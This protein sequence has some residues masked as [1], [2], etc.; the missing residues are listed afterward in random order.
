MKRKIARKNIAGYYAHISALDDYVGRVTKAI[1]ELGIEENTLLV[2]TSDHGDML[3]SQ[4]RTKKQQPWEESINVPMLLRFP[5]KNHQK[6]KRIALPINTP[7]LMP[8]FLGLC[9]LPIPSS[10][11]GKDY[12]NRITQKNDA[13]DGEEE[14]GVLITCPWMFSQFK[15]QKG[16]RE[17]RGIRTARYTYVRGLNGPWLL[18]DNLADPFQ[19][20]NIIRSRTHSKEIKNLDQ[21]LNKKLLET[22]DKFEP[23]INHINRLGY[24]TKKDGS[25]AYKN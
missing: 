7:D 21:L 18:Y 10:V 9:E 23:G 19:K 25:I 12:S 22:N 14:S 1:Q 24:K 20:H 3:Y 2:F 6:N 4:G 15:S 16:A 17:F 5:A 13:D 11:E 8:T